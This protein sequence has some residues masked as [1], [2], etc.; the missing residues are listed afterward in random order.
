[1]PLIG[2]REVVRALLE[3][4]GARTASV[5]NLVFGLAGARARWVRVDD[6]NRPRAVLCRGRRLYLWAREPAAARAA[7]AG[8]PARTRCN[9]SAMPGRLVPACRRH[10]AALRPNVKQ[11]WT[12]ACWLYELAGSP[13]PPVCGMR[14]ERLVPAD[15]AT[16]AG[17]WPHGRRVEY[18]RARILAWPSCA[19]RRGGRLVAWGLTHDDGSMGFLHVLDEWR[20]RGFARAVTAVLARRLLDRGIRPHL[21]IMQDNRASISLTESCGFRRVEDYWW[22]GEGRRGARPR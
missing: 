9:F 15:A 20:G 13:P 11:S 5:R 12:N 2:D 10:F 21:Y 14:V 8:L 4:G 17:L 6:P 7:L 3:E 18:V 1:M 19:V 22:F 16:I